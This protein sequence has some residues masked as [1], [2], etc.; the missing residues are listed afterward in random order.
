MAG[1][2]DIPKDF[3]T[4]LRD[5]DLRGTPSY[6]RPPKAPPHWDQRFLQLAGTI[7]GWSRDPSTKVG[8]VAVRDKRILGTGYNGFPSGVFDS[9]AR[10]KDRDT[11]LAL[12]VHA[13]AN[14]VAYAAKNGVSLAGSTV[15]VFP[16]MTCSS[17][18]GLLIQADI[19]RIVVPDFVEP[20]RWQ[21][22]FD[23]ARGILNEAG[24]VVERLPM[25]ERHSPSTTTQ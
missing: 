22:S 7:A 13:E 24:V 5:T 4:M 1:I 9:D 6:M 10:L 8:T 18:A 11:R 21:D 12:T 17:C 2:S 20:L 3:P 16:L 15:Y 23:A 14:L 19:S 25:S